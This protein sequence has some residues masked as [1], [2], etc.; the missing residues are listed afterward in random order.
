MVTIPDK[1][2]VLEAL[3]E[4]WPQR[5][6]DGLEIDQIDGFFYWGVCR[7]GLRESVID[8][9]RKLDDEHPEWNAILELRQAGTQ[10]SI[11]LTPH[12]R[13]LASA[14]LR[15]LAQMGQIELDAMTEIP[16]FSSWLSG[17]SSMRMRDAVFA[18]DSLDC[19]PG[20]GNAKYQ[21]DR[22]HLGVS[23]GSWTGERVE[24]VL[25]QRIALS[26]VEDPHWYDRA[27]QDVNKSIIGNSNTRRVFFETSFHDKGDVFPYPLFQPGFGS[28]DGFMP[29]PVVLKTPLIAISINYPLPR[30]G[31]TATLY[32]ASVVQTEGWNK[33]LIGK[34]TEVERHTVIRTWATALLQVSGM[35]LRDAMREVENITGESTS[36]ARFNA[37]RLNLVARV[38]EAKPFVFSRL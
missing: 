34:E 37:N 15:D 10:D 29:R 11:P 19:I 21:L 36:D 33:L 8:I 35:T 28:Y 5:F 16:N 31:I 22:V 2:K 7:T 6:D 27:E 4:I 25:R 18:R 17:G 20:R 38:P 9:I 23:A 26:Q 1:L 14:F 12:E 30:E 24:L 13:E 32:D 3:K